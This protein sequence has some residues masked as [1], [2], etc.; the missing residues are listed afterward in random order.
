MS[1]ID[2]PHVSAESCHREMPSTIFLVLGFGIAFGQ[3]IAFGPQILNIVIKKHVEGINLLTYLLGTISC[4]A[5][6]LSG[7]VESWDRFFCCAKVV[8]PCGFLCNSLRNP[9]SNPSCV[10]SGS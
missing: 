5:S 4:T 10:A 2:L 8:R 6:F 7:I 3:L 9:L 1:Y